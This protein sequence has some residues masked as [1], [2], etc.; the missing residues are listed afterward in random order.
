MSKKI[1]VAFIYRDS[2]I[3]L[4]GKHFDNVYYHFFMDA[5]SRNP[6]LEITNFPTRKNFDASILKN[7]FDIILLFQNSTFGMPDKIT[8]L[9]D[10]D[11]PVIAR[12]GD[13]P[14][15][16]P[17][18]QYH[19]KWKID[20]YFHFFPDSLFY[21]C[22]PSHFKYK[23]IIYGLEPSLYKSP[24]PFEHRIKNK[25]LN[26]GAVGNTKFFSKI[27]N[28]FRKRKQYA[29][30]GYFLRAKCNE[31]PYVDYTPTLQHTYVNDRYPILLEKYRAAIAASS[32]APT[33]KYWEI[34]AAGCL[35]FMEMTDFNQGEKILEY[36]DGESAIFIDIDNYK[37]K[38]NEYLSDFDNP[39]WQ[40]IASEGRKIA[41]NNYNN[42]KAICSLVDLMKTLI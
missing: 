9:Q 26:S 37:E 38:F 40:K 39:K 28:R 20:Y 19:K 31:L 15:A 27:I 23:C 42:D 5:L 34:P 1:K 11:I 36:V 7:R 16:K 32:D 29:L 21:Q 4:S 24:K 14:D 41:M 6:N 8:G 13:P 12:I 35:T 3:F 17:S 33:A 25:I 30:D 10:L 22:Y 2:N 18:I